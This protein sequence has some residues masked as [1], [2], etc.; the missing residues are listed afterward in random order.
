MEVEVEK[1]RPATWNQTQDTSGLSC[2]WALA[3][4]QP[5]APTILYMSSGTNLQW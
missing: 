1:G 4:G 2:H 5:P 3:T